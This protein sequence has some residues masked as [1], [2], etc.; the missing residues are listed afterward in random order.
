MLKRRGLLIPEPKFEDEERIRNVRPI[1][2]FH[3]S[4]FKH[5]INS[6]AVQ[7]RPDAGAARSDRVHQYWT[8]IVLEPLPEWNFKSSLLAADH[9]VGQTTLVCVTQKCL[10]PNSPQPLV[11][12]E[13]EHKICELMI[14]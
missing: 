1:P 6:R 10:G 14:E 13:S 12:R 7:N 9:F 3:F 2:V 8:E 4:L 11:R 5:G